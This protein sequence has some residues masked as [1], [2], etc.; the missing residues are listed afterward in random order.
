M[1]NRER[2]I[3]RDKKERRLIFLEEKHENFIAA[4]AK[5]KNSNGHQSENERAVKKM[6][7]GTHTTFPP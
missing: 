4:G 3:A 7:T 5:M 1:D 6:R 2:A